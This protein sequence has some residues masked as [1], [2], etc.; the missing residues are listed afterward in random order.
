[1]QFHILTLKRKSCD[2]AIVI[3]GC[4]AGSYALVQRKAAHPS[5]T[6]LLFNFKV[7]ISLWFLDDHLVFVILLA[8]K[9]VTTQFLHVF[10]LLLSH[11]A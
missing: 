7:Y 11:F 8:R 4:D 3:I 5:F 1:M 10:T 6:M 9:V 2:G